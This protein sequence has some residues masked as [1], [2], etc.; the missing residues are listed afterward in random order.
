[1]IRIGPEYLGWREFPFFV[2][3][4][5]NTR[6]NYSPAF[7]I[8]PLLG[9]PLARLS[10]QRGVEGGARIDI[11]NRDDRPKYPRSHTLTSQQ[12]M[13]DMPLR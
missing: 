2:V 12:F 13:P 9:Y 6:Q 3:E 10:E 8:V 1:M 7:E 11:A 4:W 5:L